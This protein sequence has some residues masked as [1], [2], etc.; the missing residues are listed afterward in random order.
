VLPA[1]N[2]YERSHLGAASSTH[3]DRRVA[4]RRGPVPIV[5]TPGARP[6]GT[7]PVAATVGAV[8]L[9]LEAL[10]ARAGETVE[11]V[12][13]CQTVG[14]LGAREPFS[15][16][17][18]ERVRL[19]RFLRSRGF[20]LDVIAH[21]DANEALLDRFVEHLFPAGR[22]PEYTLSEA[23]EEGEF[24]RGF[25]Q[26][27][28][29]AASMSDLA[30]ARGE[31][32]L[33]AV[34]N[35]S[36]VLDAGLAED[37][38]FQLVRVYADSLLRVA[39]AEVRL[40]HFY[41]HERLRAEGLTGPKLREATDAA[42]ERL[43]G[44]AEPTV[45]Y[46][47]RLG[48]RNAMR[49]DLALH[50]AQE[51]GPSEVSDIPAQLPVGV[52]FADLARFTPLT[53]AMGDTVAAQVVDRFST[54]VRATVNPWHGRVVKQ[55][56]D[57]FMLVFP[58]P[59]CAVE[60][61][62]EI[63]ARTAVEPQFP[64]VRLGAHWGEVLYREGDYVGATVNVASRVA[65]AAQPHELLVTAAMREHVEDLP[66]TEFIPLGRRALK[67]IAEDI[68]LYAIRRPHADPRDRLVDPVCGMELGPT[69]VAARLDVGDG[70][71]VFCS[72]GCLQRFV[73][74][75]DRYPS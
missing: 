39:E 58:E 61:G 5:V 38:L 25:V 23:V 64:A 4:H 19:I 8:K 3:D 56:G 59:R 67:G 40:F 2:A 16:W 74:A 6:D 34:R 13:E 7:P 44:L 42:S 29:E 24:D 28:L 36:V 27:F 9:S 48:W 11:G 22:M 51:T 73:A 21:A 18:A 26:R 41:V 12:R 52:L 14:L 50:V 31:E 55:I 54:I 35:L 70:T 57:A 75:P 10:A 65:A 60:C 72:T 45:L 46:F 53:E 71:R 63:E 20:S 49:D 37:A 15:S 47:H 62:L 1:T 33:E 17:E 43:L 66:G 30:D 69:E 68:E 32:D